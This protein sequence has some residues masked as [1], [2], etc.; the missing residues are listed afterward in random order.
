ML[1]TADYQQSTAAKN[2]LRQLIAAKNRRN[3]I[4]MSITPVKDDL[5]PFRGGLM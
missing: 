3:L 5:L 2:V 4:F 1:L